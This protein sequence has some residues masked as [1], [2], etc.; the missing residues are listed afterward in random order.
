MAQ[1]RHPRLALA[2]T[3]G[4]SLLLHA[5]VFRIQFPADLFTPPTPESPPPQ[6]AM[7]ELTPETASVTDPADQAELYTLQDFHASALERATALEQTLTNALS[8]QAETEA[9]RQQQLAALETTHTTLSGQVE[10]LTVEK[11][12]LS[13]QLADERQRRAELEQQLQETRQAKEAEL[14]GVKGAYDRLVAALKGEI[15]Q[16]EIAL[17][18]AKERLVVTILDR[19]LFPSGQATLTPEGRR[20]MDKVGAILA[21]VNDRRLVIEGH[22]DNVPISPALS[23]RFPTNWELST[24]RATEVV[25]FL[26]SETKLPANRLSAVGRADTAPVASNASEDGRKQNRRIEIILLPP[27]DQSGGLS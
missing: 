15:S 6:F 2:C 8:Q 1:H 7:I 14:S 24:A 25:K 27:E 13:A 22:T 12:D 18:Q 17:H 11:A 4:L 19:V 20:V 16:K 26:I 23:S 3:L 5:A 10:T 21:K 9:T